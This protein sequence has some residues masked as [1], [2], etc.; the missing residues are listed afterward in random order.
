MKKQTVK[1]NFLFIFLI[2]AI[3]GGLF[4]WFQIRPLNIKNNCYSEAFRLN[5]D[6]FKW[7]KGKIWTYLGAFSNDENGWVYPDYLEVRASINDAARI[8]KRGDIFDETPLILDS[9][10]KEKK[11]RNQVYKQCLVREGISTSF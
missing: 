4:Y 10:A 9:L 11:L 7:A 8:M 6:N 2:L 3:V 5:E 1:K